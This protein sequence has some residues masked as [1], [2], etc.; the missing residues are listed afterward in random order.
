MFGVAGLSCGGIIVMMP[1]LT[2]QFGFTEEMIAV[3]MSLYVLLDPFG[4][5]ANLI[6]DGALVIIVNKVLKKIET[7][8]KKRESTK[9]SLLNFYNMLM[10]SILLSNSICLL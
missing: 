1:L 3:V 2:S 4:T 5:A 10:V 9:L 8:L 6:G 7:C